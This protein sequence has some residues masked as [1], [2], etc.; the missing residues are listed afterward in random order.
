MKRALFLAWFAVSLYGQTGSLMPVPKMQFFDST[1]KVLAGGKVCTYAAGTSTPQA[2]Y[3]DSTLGTPNTNPVV[4]DSGGRANIWF[5]SNSYKVTLLTAASTTT[6][7]STGT[8][9]VIWSVDQVNG[10]YPATMMT[11]NGTQTVTGPKTYTTALTIGTGG[12]LVTSSTGTVDFSGGGLTKPAFVGTTAQITAQSCTI[13]NV[14]FSTN[15]TAGQNWYFC[16]ATNTWSQQL[17]GSGGVAFGLITGGTNNGAAAMVV[18][19]GSSL[20][21]TSTGVIK[22]SQVTDSNGNDVLR[23]VATAS[24]VD[25]VQVT[26][27]AAAN[28]SLVSVGAA[29]TDTNINLELLGKGTGKVELNGTAATVDSSGNLVVNACTGCGGPPIPDSTN[30]AYN[31]SDNTKILKLALGNL[32]TGTT[33]TWTAFDLNQSLVGVVSAIAGSGLTADLAATNLTVNGGAAPAGLYRVDFDL[34]CGSSA[35]AGAGTEAKI[36]FHT[37]KGA[38][39]IIPTSNTSGSTSLQCGAEVWAISLGNGNTAP[40]QGITP[41]LGVA[42][43]Y[44]DGTTQIT[45]STTGSS[46]YGGA[47]TFGY[48][49][50]LEKL[51]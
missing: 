8:M 46:G 24:A 48:S 50:S 11:T 19:T 6:D 21:Y 1:G 3:T 37:P 29:G 5:N 34:Y 51:N 10:A 31:A 47:N 20:T 15:A 49:A 12:S 17:N 22:A 43:F 23:P 7:C 27:G 26:N 35:T 41:A 40:T 16:T 39:S 4:L 9:N 32:T 18:G 14:A 13:G 38:V 42:T 44:H 30:L 28:P 36:S 25:Y 33:R 45:F 2:S